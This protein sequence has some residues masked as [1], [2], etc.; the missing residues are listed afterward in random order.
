MAHLNLD[1]PYFK[2]SQPQ[3][4]HTLY[5]TVQPQKVKLPA[6]KILIFHRPFIENE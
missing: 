4:S 1:S 3:R 2:F 5:Q 6:H